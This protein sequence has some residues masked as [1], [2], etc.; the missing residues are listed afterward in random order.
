MNK[1]K[2]LLAAVLAVMMLC[3]VLPMGVMATESEEMDYVPLQLYKGMLWGGDAPVEED[4]NWMRYSD[5]VSAYAD[6]N[7]NVSVDEYDIEDIDEYIDDCRHVLEAD[8]VAWNLWIGDYSAP[9]YLSMDGDDESYEEPQSRILFLD[10]LEGVEIEFN[11]VDYEEEINAFIEES[12]GY[13]NVSLF[14][15]PVFEKFMIDPQPQ[16]T[17]PDSV[18]DYFTTGVKYYVPGTGFWNVN[19]E[20]Q[21]WEWVYTEGEWLSADVVD[22]DP[23]DE[24]IVEVLYQWY[25]ADM[26]KMAVDPN[27]EGITFVDSFGTHIENGVWESKM[28]AGGHLVG[29]FIDIFEGETITIEAIE[30]EF[31]YCNIFFY[32]QD[33]A[34]APSESLQAE[35]YTAK[36]DGYVVVA[37]INENNKAFKA[38]ITIVDN[39]GGVK[40]EGRTFPCLFDAK[41]GTPELETGEYFCRAYVVD[42]D[43]GPKMQERALLSDRI[44]NEI[45]EYNIIEVLESNMVKYIK[46]APADP[47]IEEALEKKSVFTDFMKSYFYMKNTFT[48][49]DNH[50]DGGDIAITYPATGNM[51]IDVK[52]AITVEEGYEIADVL[53]DGVSVG[54]VEEYLFRGINKDHK[55]E[56]VFAPIAE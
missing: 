30:G 50:N 44:E 17:N 14:I 7:G 42:D 34:N 48:V 33:T 21:K 22:D 55:I 37:A 12:D 15:E 31:D 46:P 51:R 52:C 8:L 28:D 19:E 1:T 25:K 11:L 23:G 54:A 29:V 36:K 41:E 45:E 26:T 16:D 18:E 27:D 24:S 56:A 5:G 43:Y 3:S 35:S 49:S 13:F 38:K 47:E 40:L 39:Y 6:E 9:C 32:D 2:K 53:V 10:K 20:T 4:E